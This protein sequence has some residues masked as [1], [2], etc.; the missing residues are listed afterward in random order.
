[1]KTAEQIKAELSIRDRLEV[2]N[3]ALEFLAKT[4]RPE[5]SAILV[6]NA[7]GTGIEYFTGKPDLAWQAKA[8]EASKKLPEKLQPYFDD[9]LA[10]CLSGQVLQ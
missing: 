9:V 2:Y 10:L 8:L 3:T 5:E 6:C 1:M 4:G 7:T